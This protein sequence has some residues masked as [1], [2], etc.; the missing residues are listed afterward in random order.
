MPPIETIPDQKIAPRIRA[1]CY[2][3]GTSAVRDCLSRESA[4]SRIRSVVRF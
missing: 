4:E 3:I 1:H 2:A